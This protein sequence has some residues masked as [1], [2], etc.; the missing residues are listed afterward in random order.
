MVLLLEAIQ[1]LQQ[2]HQQVE[3]VEVEI[4]KMVPLE[5]QEEAEATMA[6][7]KLQEEVEIHHLLPLRK[8][9]QEET[10]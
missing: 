1:Y 6:L 3:V 5:V 10:L 7:Y 4:H 9:I 8:E 2:S